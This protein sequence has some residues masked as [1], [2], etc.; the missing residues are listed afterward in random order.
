M[1]PSVANCNDNNK[2]MKSLTDKTKDETYRSANTLIRMSN[3]L[4]TLVICGTPESIIDDKFCFRDYVK[5]FQDDNTNRIVIQ[6][7]VSKSLEIKKISVIAYC[8]ID[9]I[10][11]IPYAYARVS[12]RRSPYR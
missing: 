1:I 5:H 2:G 11:L 7:L 4:V 9:I 3:R 12:L 8:T 10:L 6:R